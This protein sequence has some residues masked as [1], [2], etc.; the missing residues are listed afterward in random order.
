MIQTRGHLLSLCLHDLAVR[1]LRIGTTL[2]FGIRKLEQCLLSS[3][4]VLTSQ[5]YIIEKERGKK[6]NLL[7]S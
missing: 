4:N 1:P 7:S 2:P 3:E 6:Q 5:S